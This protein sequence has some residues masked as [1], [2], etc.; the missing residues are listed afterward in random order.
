[1]KANII[2]PVMPSD[3]SV[4]KSIGTKLESSSLDVMYLPKNNLSLNR[5]SQEI[6]MDKI[7]DSYLTHTPTKSLSKLCEKYNIKSINSFI[8]PQMVYDRHYSTPSYSPFTMYINDHMNSEKYINILHRTLDWLDIMFESNDTIVSIQ[9]VGGEI[10]RRS[11][12]KMADYHN[13]PSIWIGFSPMEGMSSIFSN[14]SV[15]WMDESLLD[16]SDM[17]EDQRKDARDLINNIKSQKKQ[18]GK[19]KNNQQMS[20]RENIYKKCKLIADKKSTSI[21]IIKDWIQSNVIK[22]GNAVLNSRYYLTEKK[23]DQNI[24]SGQFIF[25]PLQYHRESRIT[26]RA[27]EFYNQFWLIEY[28]SRSC[29]SPA[30]LYIKDHP[31]QLGAQP[32][33]HIRGVSNHATLLNPHSNTH[34]IIANS[35]VVVT[36][37]N[38]VGFEAIIHGKPVVCLGNAFYSDH[39]YTFDVNNI[40]SLASTLYEAYNS[41][42]LTDEQVIEFAYGV[43]NGS[44]EGEWH[45]TSSSRQCKL[46]E[47]LYSHLLKVL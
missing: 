11:L 29:P 27:K 43:I 9:C 30:D 19:E 45:P 26:V 44:V 28:L 16:Y 47:S 46:A 34:D 42:G 20:V 25:Y 5:L 14:E 12:Q 4:V 24:R 39:G 36:L 8:F 17:D 22:K 35:N 1:M 33:S 21:P 40:S 23:S 41:D 3:I 6:C 13:M 10:L 15:D 7:Y 37:N 18:I 31:R 2:I 32:H 38:T